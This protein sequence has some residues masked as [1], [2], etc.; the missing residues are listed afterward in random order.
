MAESFKVAAIQM[1]CALFDMTINLN[2]AE[3]LIGTAANK[4]ALLAVLPELFNTGYGVEE[5]DMELANTIPGPTTNQ[6]ADICKKRGIFVTGTQIERAG[7]KLYD[8]A[9]LVGPEGLVGIYR[10]IALWGGEADR[11][12][13]GDQYRVFDIGFCRIGL[14]ICYEIGFPEGARILALQGADVIAY[15]SAFGALRHYA[16]DIASR[17]RALEN[18]LYVIACNRSG[19]EKGGTVFAADSRIVDPKG[20]VLASAAKNYDV[21]IAEV[22]PD[23]ISEQREAI[24]YLRDLNRDLAANYLRTV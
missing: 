14:Q 3:E 20:G 9:F 19:S 23:K 1:D 13:R 8:T 10:K 12:E 18:G 6:I 17:A 22:D 16:W 5:Y 24:P 4:G 15:P 21:I 11:F 2:K 7:D